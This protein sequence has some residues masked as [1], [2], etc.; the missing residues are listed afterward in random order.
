VIDVTIV[1]AEARRG[2]VR[3][4]ALRFIARRLVML[5]TALAVASFVTYAGLYLAPGSPLSVLTGGRPVS[6]D[7]IRELT[8]RYHL[9]DP[10]FQRYGLWVWDILNGRLGDSVIFHAP[11][12]DIIGQRIG[13]TIWLVAYAAVLIVVIGV[14]AGIIA[15]LRPG[16]TDAVVVTV[17]AVLAATPAF[18]AAILLLSVFAVGLGW[19]PAL[20]PGSGFLDRLWHMTLPACA[21]A[22]GTMA[23]VIR[24]TRASVRAELARE[25]VQTALSRGLPWG[26]R[27]RRHVLRN[28]A[29]PIST[30]VGVTLTSLLA[31]SAI[32]EVAFSLNGL[33]STL[34]QAALARDFSVVQAITLLIVTAFV[35][36]N[37]IVDFLS[38]LLDPRVALGSDRPRTR[39][40][41]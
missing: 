35:V 27:L 31:L 25:H 41:P 30:V 23:A 17:S 14:G 9:D 18:I 29:I 7:A 11:V 6:A 21:L 32:V 16:F 26:V 33:G 20:G 1:V 12:A 10:F 3:R 36:S 34:V 38:A 40:A 28:A 8:E 24:V 4:G 13:N 15:G 19:F 37:T 5:V 39:R 22:F 2:R